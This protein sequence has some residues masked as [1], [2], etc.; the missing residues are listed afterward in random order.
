MDAPELFKSK[1]KYILD[2]NIDDLQLNF[3]QEE[4]TSPGVRKSIDL[5]SKGSHKLVTEK[6]K[7]EYIYRL[8]KF[9]LVER[10]SKQTEALQDGF[11]SIIPVDILE[12][13]EE[14]ELE[15][16]LH[17]IREYNVEDLKRN[18][19]TVGYETFRFLQV[20]E[21]FWMALSH[22][23]NED[24][25]K[26]VQ[27]VTGSSVLPPGGWSELSPKFQIGFSGESGRLPLSYTCSN[28]ILLPNAANYQELERVLLLAVREGVDKFI[29]GS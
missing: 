15:L 20:L 3:T 27:F 13:F 5:C 8:A 21:W 14:C 2:N 23:S 10:V 6:N 22:F 11:H 28:Y 9:L 26:F 24:M 17:G 18:Y 25:A 4:E 7:Q 16:L 29:I 19:A 12:M 1:I